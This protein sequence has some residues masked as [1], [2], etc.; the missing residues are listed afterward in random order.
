MNKEKIKKFW[1]ENKNAIIFGAGCGV[2]CLIGG[3]VMYKAG[4]KDA[5]PWEP[6]AREIIN[7]IL[8]AGK[9]GERGLGWLRND[10][11]IALDDLGE[12]GKTMIADGFPRNAKFNSIIAV[13]DNPFV[14]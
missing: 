7:R 13:S 9:K 3:K 10:Y 1:K 6:E 11:G 12:F 4:M 14:K 2:G 8:M 5:I